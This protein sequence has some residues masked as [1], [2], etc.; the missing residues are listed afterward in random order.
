MMT[1]HKEGYKIIATTAV[2]IATINI[3]FGYIFPES[4]EGQNILMIASL[5]IFL[6]VVSFFRK[7][8]RRFYIDDS[9]II[10]PADGKIV[11]IEEVNE[12]EYFK[13]KRL[14]VSIFMSP[15][16][17]HINW[18]PVSG[19][20]E[21]VK[22]HPGKFLVAWHP[23]CSTSNE[24]NTIVIKD[25]DG[26]EILVR[27]I[28]GFL[29]RRIVSYPEV[30]DETAQ[31]KELGFIKFGSRVDLFLPLDAHIEVEMGQKVKG[32]KTVI[33]TVD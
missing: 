19:T 33:A 10:A 2:L 3:L 11:A 31:G 21:Y 24:R 14:Q 15:G 30:G 1:I 22:Y 13:D 17:V 32:G 29:A 6:S 20:I 4:T 26:E 5:V 25:D 7:P 23:K 8:F 27:Q 16:N 18:M 12:P 28:A 9:K